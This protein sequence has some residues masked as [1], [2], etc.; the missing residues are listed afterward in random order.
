MPTE[1]IE[2]LSTRLLDENRYTVETLKQLA[3]S[4]GLEFGWHYLLDLTWI[5]QNLGQVNGLSIMDA[6]A[7]TGVMQWYLASQGAQV[8]S[9]DRG[10]RADL[11]P[12]FRQRFNVTGL[13]QG[14]KPDLL[15]TAQVVIKNLAR[16]RKALGQFREILLGL[17]REKAP[18]SVCFYHQDLKT[19]VDI[20]DNSLDALVAVSAL[21]HNAPQDLPRVVNELMRVLKP[22]GIL[23]A[24]LCAGRDQDW[25]HQPSAGW[26]YTDASLKRLF[27]L[28]PDTPSNYAQYDSLFEALVGCAE[29]RDNLAAFYA[30]S[31]DNGMPWGKW[32]P[33]Y[34]PV[35]VCKIK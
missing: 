3:K 16:P 8:L 24:T 10:S 22:G 11:A 30:R 2:I 23:L 34:Q 17:G 1:K 7:G 27:D 21:E 5:I 20:A 35:G 9:V 14:A 18:G 32:D 13:R 31:A 26:C 6:G 25:F 4:L 19:L 12:R 28:P 15:P 33:Q 29:L